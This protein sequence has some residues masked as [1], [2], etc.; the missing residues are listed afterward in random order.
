MATETVELAAAYV[1]IIPSLKGVEGAI[2]KALGGSQAV[3]TRAGQSLGASLVA[4]MTKAIGSAPSIGKAIAAQTRSA[5]DSIRLLGAYAREASS[6]TIKELA[7]IGR[8]LA[9]ITSHITG[10]L[11]T[12]LGSVGRVASTALAPLSGIVG[13]AAGSLG[14]IGT[15]I[16]GRI[17]SS[18]SGLGSAITS[19]LAPAAGVVAQTAAKWAFVGDAIKARVSSSL[20]GLGTAISSR[21][22]PVGG[23]LSRI[24]S[25]WAPVGQFISSKVG[26]ALDGIGGRIGSALSSGASAAISTAGRIGSSIGGALSGAVQTGVNAAGLAIAGLSATI[27]GNLGGAIQRA[28]LLNNFPKV[29]GNIGYS[30]EE[31]TQQIKRI[32]GALDGLPTSTDALV[33]TAKGLAPLT[34]SLT[35]ATDV[36]L[37]LNN[38]LLAGGA[39]TALVENAMEQYRQMLANGT[40]DMQAWRSM[41]MAMPGQMDMISKSIL[42]A[43]GNTSAL[44]DAMKNGEVSFDQFNNALLSL[45]EQGLDGMASFAEQAKTATGGIGTAFTNAGNRVKK[46]LASII[47]AIGVDAIAAKINELTSGITGMGQRVA[48]AITAIKASGGEG[49]SSM[50]GP[51]AGLAPIIGA[52][53]GALGGLATNLPVIG[54]LFSGLSGPVGLVIGL[55]ASMWT[56]SEALRSAVGTAFSSLGL[57]FQSMQ[58]TIAALGGAFASIAGAL[59]NQLGA[60]LMAVTPGLVQIGQ[61]VFPILTQTINQLAPILSGLV[62][63]IGQAL[64]TALAAVM[65]ALTS[66]AQSVFPVLSQVL[67]AIA[68]VFAQLVGVIAGLFAQVIQLLAPI[69]ANLAQTLMPAILA[70]VQNLMPPLQ[71]V[72]NAIVPIV[73]AVLPVL[74]SV[75]GTLVSVLGNIIAAVLPPLSTVLGTIISV[76]GTLISTIGVVLVPT[77]RL[78][79]SVADVV[80]RAVGSI[81]M[82]LWNN[83]VSPAFNFINQ[84]L[85]SFKD[86][87]NNTL[88]PTV[89]TVATKMGEAFTKFKDTLKTAFD[90]I[91]GIAA[92]PIN[93][94]INTVYTGGIKKAFD[95]IA[96]TIGLDTRLPTVAPIAG[97]ASGGVLPGYSPGRDIYHFVSND[98]GGRLALSGGEAIMRPEW[99]RAVGGPAAVH[100]MNRAAASGSPVPGGDRGY[101]PFTQHFWD[102]GIFKKAWDKTRHGVASTIDGAINWMSDAA[103]AAKSIIQDPLGA[104]EELMLKPVKALIGQIPGSGFLTKLGGHIPSMLWEG[105]KSF[106]KSFTDKVSPAASSD[107]VGQALQALGTPYVW[108][109]VSVP[110]GVD[111]SGLIVWALRAMGYNVPRHTAASFQA[112]SEPVSSPAAGDLVFWGRPAYHVAISEGNGNIVEAPTFG[113]PVREYPEYGAISGYGRFRYDSGGFLQPGF[114]LVENATGKPEPVFTSSQWDLLENRPGAFPETVILKVGDREFTAYVDERATDV[115]VQ[116][117]NAI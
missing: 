91:K 31:A 69:L 74:A 54:G 93:F 82:W 98:G 59:G 103:E 79:G 40:V 2:A 11:R 105:I 114:T 117:I 95:K 7:P 61:I 71:S 48:D 73:Q 27:A 47:E 25:A 12:A 9:S 102:G 64:T 44:Y 101:R 57:I 116:A 34:G 36:S 42:G 76:L 37:A 90:A 21:L 41:T 78:M 8:A 19:R 75:L 107:L 108:G 3:T 22:A 29:M 51:L 5:A 115:A 16:S 50:L 99:V 72:I 28:D 92:K 30:S 111:C 83:A 81:V 43:S 14:G 15:A 39:S 77:F 67:T 35:K 60:A 20:S 112:N 85:T 6:T 113:I 84:K 17:G 1:Q 10:P 63:T 4:G 68:P 80:I 58:P 46:A 88:K 49:L 32:S 109:G 94:V 33:Q 26:G 18:L 70:V 104:L 97:Y 38:A 87:L 13:K 55:F 66:L 23:A 52:V 106:I 89:T 65:P 56:Q 96:E 62:V 53:V 100:A 86:F 24:G 45:N 110:G